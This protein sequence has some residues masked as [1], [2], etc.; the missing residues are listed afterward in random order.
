MCRAWFGLIG[1]YNLLGL[2]VLFGLGVAVVGVHDDGV[3]DGFAPAVGAEGVDVFVLGDVDALDE[4]LGEIG[5]GSGGFGFDV[6]AGDG[7][8]KAAEG[9]AEIARRDAFSGEEIR[10]VAT[11]FIGGLGLGLLAG[12]VEAEMRMRAGAGSAATAAIGKHK[13]TQGHAN[14]FTCDRRAVN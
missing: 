3:A 1:F 9:G 6:A 10:E 5:E 4:S 12:M 14:F 8:Q 13:T 11:E 7:S 2:L